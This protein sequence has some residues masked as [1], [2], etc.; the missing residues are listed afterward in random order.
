MVYAR[1]MIVHVL[2]VDG[3]VVFPFLLLKKE[4][5]KEATQLKRTKGGSRM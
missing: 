1:Y 4:E 5:E 3:G 2:G